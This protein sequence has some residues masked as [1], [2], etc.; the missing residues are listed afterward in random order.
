[1]KAVELHR[2]PDGVWSCQKPDSDQ[3]LTELVSVEV[4]KLSEEQDGEPDVRQDILVDVSSKE[5]ASA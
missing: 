3:Q 4:A 2:G 5:D 1:M